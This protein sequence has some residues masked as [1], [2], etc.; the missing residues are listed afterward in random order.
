MCTDEQLLCCKVCGHEKESCSCDN[1][2]W[3][4]YCYDYHTTP[5]PYEEDDYED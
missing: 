4:S 3:C 1:R 5:C 2:T